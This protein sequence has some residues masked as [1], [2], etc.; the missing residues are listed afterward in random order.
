MNRMKRFLVIGLISVLLLMF[1]YN[2]GHA[3]STNDRPNVLL[4]ITDDQGYADFGAYSKL[5]DVRTPEMDKLADS[6]VRFTNAYVTMSICSPSR[7]GIMTGRQQQRW[8]VYNYGAKFPEREVTLAE[9]LHDQG[10][11]TGMV[12]KTHYGPYTGPGTHEF[13]TGHG[14]EYFFGKEGG[15]MDYLRHTQAERDIYTKQMADHLGIGPFWENDE[16]VEVQGYSTDIILEKSLDYIDQHKNEPFFLTVSFNAVHLFTHQIP[17]QDLKAMGIDKVAD[18]DPDKGTWDEYLE[19]Y[20]NTVYPETPE[21]RQRYLYHLEKL[22]DAVGGLIDKLKKEGLYENTIIVYISD[23]GGSPRTYSSNF[24]LKGNKYILEEGGIRVPFVISWPE[25]LKGGKVYKETVMATDIFPTIH[26]ALGI[27]LPEREM[28]GIDLF[29]YLEGEN[30]EAPHEWAFWTGFSMKGKPRTYADANGIRARHDRT[31]GGDQT[32][33]AVRYQDWKLRY[34]GTTG[35]YGLYNLKKDIGEK[36]NLV[37]KYPELKEQM[38][39]RF[40]EWHKSIQ[41]AQKSLK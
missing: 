6:G 16:Q 31:L 2:A 7:L 12:G 1:L 9:Q 11:R 20:V 4:I 10:Y 33:W 21:G 23:N 30:K 22:D 25:K 3:K 32:G 5:K 39:A 18:W 40:M 15:T 38:E 24:P 14:F 29:P 26:A 36:K 8:G 27:D 35:E 37:K 19:W 28:D 17:E 13:P 34:F 41:E